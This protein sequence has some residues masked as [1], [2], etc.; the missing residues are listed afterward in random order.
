MGFFSKVAKS[1]S[2]DGQIEVNIT[3]ALERIKKKKKKRDMM[4]LHSR[5]NQFFWWFAYGIA[6]R[7]GSLTNPYASNEPDYHK[8]VFRLV[9]KS[10]S[11][12]GMNDTSGGSYDLSDELM[13]QGSQYM[14]GVK[15]F[16]KN[17]YNAAISAVVVYMKS[18]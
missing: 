4:S 1:F 13:H 16:D 17:Q 3:S 10:L 8:K 6:T 7:A 18:R 11:D 5:D 12:F 15:N 9:D 14:F 2:A